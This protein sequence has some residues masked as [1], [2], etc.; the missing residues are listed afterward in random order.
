MGGAVRFLPVGFV[1]TAAFNAALLTRH[2]ASIPDQKLIERVIPLRVDE[3]DQDILKDWK[4]GKAILA[5]MKKVAEAQIAA[6]VILNAHI[7]ILY[8]GEGS[9]WS[10]SE[11][12][13]YRTRTCLIPSPG[14]VTFVGPEGAVLPVG[15]VTFVDHTILSS[16][17]NTGPCARLHLVVDFLREPEE[18]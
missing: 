3:E 16:D 10:S 12:A 1:D 11:A 13:V 8:P 6:P 2:R 14:A 4:S 9:A 18:S 15:Q 17:I 5:R 7:D